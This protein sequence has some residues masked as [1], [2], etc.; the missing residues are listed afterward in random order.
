MFR[1][2]MQKANIFTRKLKNKFKKTRRKRNMKN[3]KINSRETTNPS[4][5]EVKRDMK[6]EQ[7]K[8]VKQRLGKP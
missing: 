7:D 4:A 2:Q 6:L 1:K 5:D 3:N 8:R